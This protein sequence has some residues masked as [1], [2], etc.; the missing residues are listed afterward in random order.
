MPGISVKLEFVRASIVSLSLD[1]SPSTVDR[2]SNSLDQLW[3][4][5]NK[6]YLIA[7][8]QR[9]DTNTSSLHMRSSESGVRRGKVGHHVEYYVC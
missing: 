8:V 5:G 7:L 2:L 3:L 1:L 6:A 9:N 4:G